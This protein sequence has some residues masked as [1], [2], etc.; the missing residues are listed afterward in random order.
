[1]TNT[2]VKKDK[3]LQYLFP[4][5]VSLIVFVVFYPVLNAGFL[6][7][8]DHVIFLDI[9]NWRGL[10]WENLYW[11]FTNFYAG[12]WRPLMWLTMGAIYKFFGLNPVLYHLIPLLFHIITSLTLYY[13]ILYFLKILRKQD[14]KK[15]TEKKNLAILSAGLATLFF[16]LHPLRVESVA[17][18]SASQDIPNALF[19]CL[20]LFFYIKAKNETNHLRYV[21]SIKL[22]L[23]CFTLSLF[24]KTMSV[25]LPVIFLIIDF[26]LGDRISRNFK[27]KPLLIEKIPFF[28]VA[29]AAAIGTIIGSRTTLA[30]IED[31][32]ILARIQQFLYV[33]FFY[34]WKTL[35]PIVLLPYYDLYKTFKD[36]CP[37]FLLFYGTLF[38]FITFILIKAR[39]KT[40]LGIT[41]WLCYLVVLTPVSGLLRV[42]KQIVSDRYSYIPGL[43]FSLLLGIGFF[44]LFSRAKKWIFPV[45][46]SMI[47]I[48]FVLARKTWKQT[49]IWRDSISLWSYVV[50]KNTECERAYNNL[51]TEFKGDKS[52]RYFRKVLEINPE[53][54]RAK[55]NIGVTLAEMGDWLEAKKLFKEVIE[56]KPDHAQSYGNLGVCFVALGE[57]NKATDVF[58][59]ALKLKPDFVL[60]HVHLASVLAN[61]NKL[62]K[63]IYHFKKAIE[64][65]KESQVL[66]EAYLKLGNVFAQ[67]NKLD[68]AVESYR[69]TLKLQPANKEAIENMKLALDLLKKR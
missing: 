12:H 27:K 1:V 56:K 41:S 50:E 37:V 66:A 25:T 68:L 14:I 7:W 20:S 22:S 47:F 31:V 44:V 6:N 59:K 5:F 63:S 26:F 43:I 54:I 53:N 21:K 52:I 28:I 62:D 9:Y 4:V 40:A 51:G 33:P 45:I 64:L 36:V 38:F 55:Y 19:F 2:L 8:D 34:V 17:W 29:M 32:S 58:E 23:L 42:V 10:R 35:F 69:E 30:T 39:Q 3:K 24:Y 13:T 65:S 11:M 15:N 46:V 18:L 67:Q 16:S 48:L 49:H 60:V 61:T 57:L